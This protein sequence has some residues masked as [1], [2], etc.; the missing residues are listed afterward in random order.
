VLA[1]SRR[2]FPLPRL[3]VPKT[4]GEALFFVIFALFGGDKIGENALS[5]RA[6]LVS[7]VS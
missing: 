4:R 5:N 2:Q 7:G 3:L 1:A 6:A